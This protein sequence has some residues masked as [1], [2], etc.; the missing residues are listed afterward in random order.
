MLES[1][2]QDVRYAARSLG[3]TPGFAAAAIVTL[4]LGIGANTAIFSLIEAVMLR[5][6]PVRAPEELYFVAHR[7]A[8][9]TE[10]STNSNF[11]WFERVQQRTDVFAGVAAYNIRN[12]KVATDAGVEQVTGQYVSGNYHAL[13]GVPMALGRGF[14]TEND[15]AA[16]SSPYAVISDRYW[17]RRFGRSP[18][19][20]GRTLTVGGLP[21]TI[22][23]V[24]AAG[25][26][27]LASGRFVDVTLPLSIRIQDQPDFVS[28]T[29]AWT[30]M[31]LV[32]RLKP[33]VSL[34][35]AESVVQTE[36]RQHLSMPEMRG[37]GRGRTA[38][39]RPAGRGADR[40][41]D[42]YG[43]ALRVLT[44]MV[45][46]V[47][48]IA[49]VN[50]ANLLLVRGAAG[51][52]DIA[53]RM[54]VG[55][56]RRR[57][58]R[59]LLTE[60]SLLALCGGAVGFLLAGWGTRFVAGILRSG[61]DPVFI[62][63][64]PNVT[65]LVFAA[66]LSMLTGI[67]FGLAP[68]VNATGVDLKTT[69]K[70]GASST[71]DGRRRRR[72][73]VAAQL[74]LSVV[75][76][77]A[78]ALLVRTLQNLRSVDAGVTTNNVL[79]FALDA[80][81]SPFP[82][83]G[84]GPLCDELVARLRRQPG[85]LNGSCSTMIPIDEGSDTYALGL[86]TPPPQPNAEDVYGNNITPGYFRTFGIEVLR[87]RPLNDRD[88]S[89]APQSAVVNEAF[90]RFYFPGQDALGQTIGLGRNG[91][92]RMTIVGI[93]KDAKQELRSAPPRM[94]YLPLAQ[95]PQSSR[96]LTVAL[97][98][99]QAPD[100]LAGTIRPE[101]QAL[102]RDVAVRYVR[103]MKEQ[104]DAAL[105][106][107]R[108]LATLSG[109]FGALALLLACV[110]LYGVI[111][112]D[113]ARHRRDIGVRLALGANRASVLATVL[114]DAARITAAGLIAGVGAAMLLAEAVSRFLFGVSPHDPATLAI[115][116]LVL[117]AT[118]MLAG[119]LPARRA[120]RLDP[121][122]ALRAE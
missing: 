104:I 96:Q 11:P 75:L 59:Q 121:A 86:P 6:V 27:G 70:G 116:A 57:V 28:W 14:S 38:L 39:L 65:V 112:Y 98:T 2:W 79:L 1:I 53:L 32:A 51:A 73:L 17:A 71:P 117:G 22:V 23:G 45:G 64:E 31:P 46:I 88:L 93:V 35:T 29:D 85:V 105:V 69:L 16:G 91:A 20:L 109:A 72:V 8:D 113:V 76:L 54:S 80:F 41:R 62:D 48:L 4:A 102:T 95:A 77:F 119:Y 94:V 56:T 49:C 108:L 66:G 118:A 9:D 120:S 43:M 15:R 7:A 87:G 78:A 34:S 111:S 97:Q 58:L 110:G 3:R 122:V 33:G 47:L 74:A 42:E 67:A 84:M 24:T 81:D 101:L 18:G 52:K 13:I 63:V 26:D 5:T 103:T 83:E 36:Y 40:L 37:F 30:G 61:Q 10:I 25:F 21:V 107:E 55:A 115:A 90:V 114:G 82:A 92:R 60:S 19:A 50:V 68:A 89:N 106:S 99:S 44:A 100:A 12:F